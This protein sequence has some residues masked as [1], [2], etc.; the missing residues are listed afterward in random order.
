VRGAAK[1]GAVG[2]I[3]YNNGD[4]NLEGYSLQLFADESAPYVPTAGISQGAG[5]ALAAL[6]EAGQEIIIEVSTEARNATTY[7]INAQTKGGDQDN[8]IH[9]S[10]HSDSVAQGPGINDNGSGSISLLEIA[11]QLTNFTVNK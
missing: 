9:I 1:K 3:V 10:G 11:I 4:G 5:E 8:V 2:V 6:L 7:N